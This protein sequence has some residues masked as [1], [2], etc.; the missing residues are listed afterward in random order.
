MSKSYQSGTA[1]RLDTA[2]SHARLYAAVVRSALDAII[3]VDEGGYVISINPAAEAIFGYSAADAVGRSIG[4]LIVPDHHRAAHEAGMAR[5]HA[6]RVPHVLGRR[7]MM[8]ARCR[9]GRIIP[10]ELAITEVEL[11]DGRLFTAH[12]RDLSSEQA[13]SEE[14]ERQREALYQ[15][16]KLAA[17][18]SL[19]AGVAHELNN[20][21][22][23]VL[24]Q[25]SMLREE[26]EADS[27]GPG[28][29]DRA[30]AIEGAA[31][32]CA[33]VVRSF[34]SIARQRK[35]KKSVFEMTELL[36]ASL[37]LVAYG[38]AS[39]GIEVSRDYAGRF[40]VFAD[41][42]QVQN[43]IV[44]LLVNAMQALDSVERQRRIDVSA[45]VDPGCGLILS[46][47]DNG[48]GIPGSIAGRIFDP[49]FTTKPQGV[50]TG[51][52]LAISRG[53]AEAQG[54]QLALAVSR[55]G[56]AAFELLLPLQSAE[57]DTAQWETGPQAAMRKPVRSTTGCILVIDDEPEISVLLAQA[58]R[59]AGYECELASGGLSAQSLIAKAPGRYG[60][61]VCDLRMPGLDGPGLFRWLAEHHP[62]LARKTVFVTGDTLGPVAGRFLA[63]SPRP[64]LEK[65]FTP[66][67][68]VRLVDDVIGGN[69]P[70]TTETTSKAQDILQKQ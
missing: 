21:L 70:E 52:G 44:N 10:V 23:V 43:I 40:Q 31:E 60:A 3:V 45:H 58:L 32:R 41:R 62:H 37:E 63:D 38:L 49:F 1:P 35:A 67:E 9:D 26:M 50:G 36:D 15:N 2:L 42:D 24:G 14:I 6:T 51:I 22:S 66:A 16:E 47:D 29:L 65:P 11:P 33:R 57:L 30:I 13:A 7:V 17:I 48:P 12:L 27:S 25:A 28:L 20:P 34:L 5:Y 54:G 8:D 55:L 46:I 64:V 68:V 56:G 19:L 53:L 18:G 69:V 61:V 59:R 4:A 39:T